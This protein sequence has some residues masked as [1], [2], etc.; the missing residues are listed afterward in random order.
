MR[1]LDWV[2]VTLT[3]V[4][5]PH[6]LQLQVS[7]AA[8]IILLVNASTAIIF[9][10]HIF[11]VQICQILPNYAE[12]N[13]KSRYHFTSSIAQISPKSVK[14]RKIK[15]DKFTAWHDL[16]LINLCFSFLKMSQSDLSPRVTTAK[17]KRSKTMEHTCFILLPLFTY[18]LHRFHFTCACRKWVP[19]G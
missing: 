12:I 17:A 1:K 2:H 8:A 10:R 3:C 11:Y 14:L 4:I 13:P 7:T 9:H 6:F 19:R 16:P 18:R 5:Q 15:F